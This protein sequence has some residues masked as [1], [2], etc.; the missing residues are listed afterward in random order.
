MQF[1]LDNPQSRIVFPTSINILLGG[2]G[3]QVALDNSINNPDTF[4]LYLVALIMLWMVILVPW[5]LLRIFLDHAWSFLSNENPMVQQMLTGIRSRVNPLPPVPPI[6]PPSQPAGTARIA[7]KQ[8]AMPQLPKGAGQAKQL[9]VEDRIANTENVRQNHLQQQ[10]VNSELLNLTNLSIPTIRDIAKYETLSKSSDTRTQSEISRMR[11]TLLQVA[12]PMIVAN[13]IEREKITKI[14]ERLMQTGE[15]GNHM[16]TSI[17]KAA[18][19]VSQANSTNQ[20]VNNGINNVLNQLANP[21]KVESIQ[22][23]ERLKEIKE[24]LVKES[25]QGNELATTLLSNKESLKGERLKEIKEKLIDASLAGDKAAT[26]ILSKAISQ[27]DSVALQHALTK[28]DN[29]SVLTNEKEKERF[30]KVKEKLVQAQQQGSALASSLLSAIKNT[31]G[32]APDINQMQDIK[33]KIIDAKE[34]GDLLAVD[35]LTIIAAEAIIITPEV[36]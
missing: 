13:P 21:E 9:P 2:P 31:V 12:N 22:D 15:Q 10:F 32:T 18:T 28:L 29:P 6:A 27:I 7:F 3:Q 20:Q 35:M 36:K 33:E 1:N 25:Q 11:Q 17:L 16:A 19:I 24:T 8:Y 26:S 5:I 30:T 4:A 34:H 14:R 23:K